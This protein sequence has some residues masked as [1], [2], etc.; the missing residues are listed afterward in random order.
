MP[1]FTSISILTSSLFDHRGQYPSRYDRRHRSTLSM[2]NS[3]SE[4]RV[5]CF[6]FRSQAVYEEQFFVLPLMRRIYLPEQ[7][8]CVVDDDCDDDGVAAKRERKKRKK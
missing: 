3:P 5:P 1:I 8:C 2:R 6:F 7:K 4:L